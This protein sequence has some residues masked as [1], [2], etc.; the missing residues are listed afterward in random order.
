MDPEGREES[1]GRDAVPNAAKAL[2]HGQQL[3]PATATRDSILFALMNFRIP[4]AGSPRAP[5]AER[6][7]PYTS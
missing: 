6:L 5:Q 4:Q 2:F 3:Q 1:F 7:R